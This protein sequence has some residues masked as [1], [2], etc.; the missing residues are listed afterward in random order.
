MTRLWIKTLPQ[1]ARHPVMVTGGM[2]IVKRWWTWRVEVADGPLRC[3]WLS[4]NGE[5]ASS[6]QV[7]ERLLSSSPM[8][9]RVQL[10]I[11]GGGAKIAALM[12]ALEAVDQLQ[13]DGVIHVTR[14]AG[15][16]AGAIVG[17]L[18]A[19]G[20]GVIQAA[21]N[22]LMGIRPKE[23]RALFPSPLSLAKPHLFLRLLR[24]HPVWEAEA[25]EAL[26]I[27]MLTDNGTK[28]HHIADLAKVANR[29]IALKILAA[30]L[31][32]SGRIIY[33]DGD[34][35]VPSLMNSCGLP[36]CFRTWS[37]N[38]SPVIVDGGI[39]ENL[40]SDE[41][42]SP[43]DVQKYGPVV[44]ITFERPSPHHIN[45]AVKFSAA[46]LETAMQNSMERARQRLGDGC[47]FTIET[48]LK[49]F[50]FEE[51]LDKGFDLQGAY[52][53]VK[54]R[55][56][57][58]FGDFVNRQKSIPTLGSKVLVG[59]PWANQ[60]LAML[61]KVG[62]IYKLH[63]HHRVPEYL[64]SS[65]VVRARCFA[66]E[67]D[68]DY[69]Q[70]DVI[71]YTHKL[72]PKN[73][74][75]FCQRRVIS[76][77]LH[78]SQVNR[79]DWSVTDLG[80]G[81]QIK[82]V[83]LPMRSVGAKP[84]KDRELLLF[85]DPPLEPH[86]GPYRFEFEDLIQ[87]FMKPLSEGK[88]DELFYIVGHGEGSVGRI[89]LVV[90]VPRDVPTITISSRNGSSGR[91]MKDSELEGYEAPIGYRGLGWTATNIPHGTDFGINLVCRELATRD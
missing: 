8:P 19:A 69:R 16:S 41:L 88:P 53:F 91:V 20:P 27:N 36:F 38:G 34:A 50:D 28:F 68:A 11:Q 40:P 45:S 62:E 77:T 14:I 49:T 10:A 30:D 83:D 25:I 44:G 76:G 85:L 63:H 48:S 24:G 52:G 3:T 75:I 46:L 81:C 26:L 87:D 64:S 15:T 56:S 32:S 61:D 78:E 74:T 9:I 39:C 23:I 70:P 43:S 4:P 51:A 31:S 54:D 22:R 67:G 90:F 33:E 6:L 5:R 58:W 86:S 7:A 82:A 13:S 21:R 2:T 12:A 17:A 80:R 18:Y 55:A 42:D 84:G 79:T 89:D 71:R 73:D 1:M 66:K 29:N 72:R 60:G 59:D 57:K 37:K 35:L 47:L 65:V